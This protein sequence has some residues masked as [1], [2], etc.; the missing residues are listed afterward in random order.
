MNYFLIF[1]FLFF[2]GS[3][4]GW[5]M[6][7]FFR[8][9]ISVNNPERVWINPGFLTGPYLPLYGFGLWG[10]YEV[11][12]L[13][14]LMMTDMIYL[15]ILIIFAVM[16]VIMTVIE[17][18]AGL[19]FVRGMN[20]KLWDYSSER[21]NVKGVICLKFTLIWGALGTVYFFTLNN[22]V[23]NWVE[24]LSHHLTFSFFI[25]MFFGVFA[26]DLGYTLQI[27][28][29]IRRFAAENDIVVK[30]EELKHF[31]RT[32]RLEMKEKSRFLLAFKT[33]RPLHEHLERYFEQR[34]EKSRQKLEE[35]REDVME[36]IKSRRH[37]E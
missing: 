1:A 6:E 24:W 5:C 27:S 31:L 2:I 19:I 36:K 9:F 10:M 8:R 4:L 28:V 17:Y 18:I 25:G 32:Q 15:N 35:A 7:L 37:S 29:K 3:C 20:V 26:V 23:E 16:A 13:I 21:F 11:S 22:R 30:Y 33:D 14:E 34:M 12:R